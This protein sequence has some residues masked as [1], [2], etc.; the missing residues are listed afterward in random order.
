MRQSK[1]A[2]GYVECPLVPILL[3]ILLNRVTGSRF[4]CPV[5]LREV[6]IMMGQATTQDRRLYS[7]IHVT[8]N[9]Q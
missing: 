9:S 6:H 8:R 3:K 5:P 7:F 1:Q 4:T 2:N